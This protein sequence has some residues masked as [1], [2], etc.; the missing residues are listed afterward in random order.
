M[1][2]NILREKL[3]KFKIKKLKPCLQNGDPECLP[4]QIQCD[5]NN[6]K[7]KLNEIKNIK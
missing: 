1:P 2:I 4:N 6:L 7:N 5:L 3:S